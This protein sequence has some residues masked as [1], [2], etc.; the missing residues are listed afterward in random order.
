MVITFM[1]FLEKILT[2]RYLLVGL[3]FFLVVSGLK[4]ALVLGEDPGFGLSVWNAML[5][6]NPFN[7]LS[8]TSSNNIAETQSLFL[9][10]WSPGQYA[11]PGFLSYLLGLSLGTASLWITLLFS[12]LGLIGWQ[13]VYKRLGF[14][15]TIIALCILF[16]TTSRLFTINFLNYT[17]GELLLFG[18]Q[19]WTIWFYLRYRSEPLKLFTGLLLLS[20]VCFFFK[21]AY[22]IGLAALGG[23]AGLDFGIDF[24]KKKKILLPTFWTVIAVGF[25]MA[26][27]LLIT[28][29]G[30]ISLGTSPITSTSQPFKIAWTSFE[31]LSYPL[32]HW[33]S[34]GE[35]YPQ[36]LLRIELPI[37]GHALYYLLMA[38]GFLFLVGIILHTQ[39][40]EARSIFIC[41][42]IVYCGVFLLL[43]NKGANISIEYRHTK[44]VAYL[45]L[46]LLLMAL[47]R[48]KRYLQLIFIIILI[49]NTGY[50]L[51]SFI[52][53]K[54]EIQSESA[55]GKSGFSLRHATTED[56][57]LIHEVDL[58]QNI[59]YF[60][61]GS[62]NVEASHA[63]KLVGSIDFQFA[64]DCGFIFDRYEGKAGKIY[65]FVHE[66]YQQNTNNPSLEQ[67]FPA[68]QFQ[69]IK[70]TKKFKIY[71]GD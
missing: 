13:F 28:Q 19:P 16:I 26:C 40:V 37:W 33:F 32:T 30:F 2:H 58:P 70:Q 49:L 6:G 24:L 25:C 11:V 46:P 69:L 51:A 48:P 65:A 9:T 31:T 44:I 45:F 47:R 21:T 10:W 12:V 64:K 1:A 63:R 54:I 55:L 4:V 14:D 52:I 23:C 36:L 8:I 67:Q 57:T 60:T 41:F 59:L 35:I 62:L 68:Y 61:S 56:I 18:S 27:Y 66:A 29:L 38:L 7:T 53:K 50:G 43:Y 34:I 20:L 15:Q 5:H 3:L 71:E 22:T 42:F 39:H 17:G